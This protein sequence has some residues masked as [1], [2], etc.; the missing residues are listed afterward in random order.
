MIEL[1]CK[2][3]T[4]FPNLKL[5]C[6]KIEYQKI[7][8]L[9]F[10]KAFDTV[11]HD[12]LLQ[13][14]NHYGIRGI[15]LQL[16]K[17]YLT[18]REQCVQLNNITSD[19]ELIKHGVPQGSIL[20]PLFFL[21]YINDIANSSSLL[22][23]YFFAD[24]TTI[25]FSHKNTKVVEKIIN[26]ELVH[27]SNWLVAN[28]LSLNVGKSNVLLFRGKNKSTPSIN[29]QI[30]GI[31]VEEKEHTKY[32]GIQIDNKLTFEKHIE[33]VKSRLIKGNAILSMVRHYLPKTTLLK[34]YNA[35]VQPHIDYGLN[36]WGHTFKTHLSPVKRQQRK[37]MRLMNF[38]KKQDETAEL[39]LN[40]KV[41]PFDKNLMLSSAKLLWKANNN[42]LPSTLNTLF[43]KRCQ[44]NSF[45]LPFRRL[46]ITQQCTTYQ[47]VQVWN[48]IPQGLRSIKSLNEFKTRYKTHLLTC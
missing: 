14:L 42:L 21:L 39:F 46:D 26:D 9:D 41:L 2:Y 48:R 12:I 38:K 36:V 4:M 22:T 45:H 16:I 13:K 20:G 44:N 31:S 33:H 1:D 32:L 3:L 23:F 24:D 35:Y 15:T 27:V 6:V 11:N 43:K 47:G 18:D 7:E 19:L 25:F 30:N 8:F 28:K 29:I 10:A 37:S 34:T 5:F 17:S 40:D